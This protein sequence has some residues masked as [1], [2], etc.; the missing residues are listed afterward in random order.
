MSWNLTFRSFEDKKQLTVPAWVVG[1][2]MLAMTTFLTQQL[3][4]TASTK[5]TKE[6]IIFVTL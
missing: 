1:S 5:Y 3:H 4:L 6:S 2:A